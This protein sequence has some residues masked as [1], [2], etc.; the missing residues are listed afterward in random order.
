MLIKEVEQILQMSS[1]TIRY[2]ERMGLIHPKRNENEYRN[3]SNEDIEQL[4]RIRFLRELEI[5]V[6]DISAILNDTSSFQKVLETHTK[7]LSVKIKSLQYVQQTC[8]ELKEKDI[9]LLDALIN[10][11][12]IE[13]EKIDDTKIVEGLR[14]VIHYLKPIKTVIIGTRVDPHNYFPGLIF[15]IFP[16][17]LIALGLGIGIPSTINYTN[18]ILTNAHIAP[19]SN[20]KPSTLIVV[21]LFIVSYLIIVAI[22]GRSMSKQSYIELTDRS[23][24]ICDPRIQSKKSIYLGMLLKQASSRNKKYNYE[25]LEKVKIDLLF[26]TTSGGRSGLWHI[27]V[28]KFTFIFLDGYHYTSD[29]GKA[30]GEKIGEAYKILKNKKIEIETSKEIIEYFKQDQLTVYEYFENIYHHNSKK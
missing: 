7:S 22:H 28:P 5:P 26:S 3:Y 25:E 1:Y 12:I 21:A 29:G 11:S 17:L 6:E 20:F 13:K 4:K 10:K 16:A 14:S 9:P 18:K 15:F 30:F 2:Y 23:I 27:Y 24:N 8:E 19:L